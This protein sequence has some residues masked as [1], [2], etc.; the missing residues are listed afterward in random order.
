MSKQMTK[1]PIGGRGYFKLSLELFKQLLDLP[2]EMEITD[3]RVSQN[4]QLGES[5]V[6]MRIQHP[7]LPEDLDRYGNPY[8]VGIIY[9]D[10]TLKDWYY[11]KYTQTTT[12]EYIHPKGIVNDE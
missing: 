8:E 7:L 9:E 5:Y 10:R 6:S 4:W 12:Q 3:I 2:E 11:I 1:T